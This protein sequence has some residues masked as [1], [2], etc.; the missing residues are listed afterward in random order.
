[1]KGRALNKVPV[2]M[3]GNMN[4]VMTKLADVAMRKFCYRWRTVSATQEGCVIVTL[5]SDAAVLSVC[6]ALP[7]CVISEE[8]ICVMRSPLMAA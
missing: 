7:V 5:F 1:M 2:H 8:L 6:V 3:L 4:Q